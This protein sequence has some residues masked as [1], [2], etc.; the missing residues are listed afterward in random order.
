[1][2]R[3]CAS[4]QS[5]PLSAPNPCWTT[6]APSHTPSAVGLWNLS[7]SRTPV[8]TLRRRLIAYES[9][10]RVEDRLACLAVWRAG[11]AQD[12]AWRGVRAHPPV[13]RRAP[14]HGRRFMPPSP[15]TPPLGVESRSGESHR[16]ARA[17]DR[18][19]DSVRD[20]PHRGS[21][22]PSAN[23]TLR[24]LL[25]ALAP[26]AP[27]SRPTPHAS[28]AHTAHTPAQPS[29]QVVAQARDN[30]GATRRWARA[31]GHFAGCQCPPRAPGSGRSPP[32]ARSRPAAGWREDRPAAT[33][34]DQ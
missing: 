17:D 20:G 31:S 33:A 16:A 15:T 30:A 22:K 6:R 12:P 11:V 21:G 2:A 13:G 10:R 8:R 19:G 7:D 32:R 4:P 5:G 29:C 24:A 14:R 27:D 3:S 25:A 34:P 26:A 18:T 23:P 28:S 1:M 9:R